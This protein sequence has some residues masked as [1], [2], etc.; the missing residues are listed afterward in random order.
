M[1]SFTSGSMNQADHQPSAE[2]PTIDEALGWEGHVNIPPSP[3]LNTLLRNLSEVQTG[4]TF[5]MVFVVGVLVGGVLFAA[6]GSGKRHP[7]T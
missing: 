6:L 1:T 7:D 3:L 4:L 2:N 5:G